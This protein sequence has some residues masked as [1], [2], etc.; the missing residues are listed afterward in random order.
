MVLNEAIWS[1]FYIYSCDTA[2]T[3]FTSKDSATMWNNNK[4]RR[5]Q[6]KREKFAFGPG[7]S[8]K[9]FGKRCEDLEPPSSHSGHCSFLK[10][11]WKATHQKQQQCSSVCSACRSRHGRHRD[12][13][14]RFATFQRRVLWPL[15]FTMERRRHR[16]Q[17]T[18]S[19]NPHDTKT[20]GLSWSLLPGPTLQWKNARQRLF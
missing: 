13:E 18:S 5:T 1:L 20:P 10:K 7:T 6:R 3:L 17:K 9:H 16:A 11:T 19:S 8:S 2:H 15:T 14:Q 12:N 4:S